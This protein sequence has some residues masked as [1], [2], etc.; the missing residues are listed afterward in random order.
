MSEKT[1]FFHI[2]YRS[3]T[4]IKLGVF[5]FLILAVSSIIGTLL[6]QGIVQ[7]ELSSSYSAGAVRLIETLGLNDFYHTIWFR[8]LL[9]LLCA[10]I[11]VCSIERL[12]K[13]LKLLRHRKQRI[14]PQKLLKFSC[15]TELS[16][17]LPWREAE[18]RLS[19]IIAEGFE[20]VKLLEYDGAY[21]GVVEKGRWNPLLVYVVHSS[22][23]LIL[24]G[25][26]IGSVFGFE[27]F[28]TLPE[29]ETSAEVTLTSGNSTFMLPFQIRCD[30]FEVSFYDTGTPKEFR[31]D[32][33]IIEKDKEIL[34]QSIRVN[35][36]LTFKGISFYQSTYGTTLK[37]SNLVLQD[38]TTGNSH[39][40]TLPYRE[41]QTIP[42][43]QDKVQIVEYRQDLARFGPAI[44]VFIQRAGQDEPKGAWVLVNRPEFHGNHA[45]NYQI[46]VT[47]MQQGQYTGLHVKQDPGI[48]VVYFGFTAML[49]GIGLVCFSSHRRLWVWAEPGE[50][51]CRVV[52]AGKT[53]KNSLAFEQEFNRI[54]DRL[55]DEWEHAST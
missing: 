3:L 28:M 15:S 7:Q 18:S 41:I 53:N 30:N 17:R 35:D 37:Q 21:S 23:L 9:L 46:K 31:S 13:T 33:T 55:R 8:L 34:K 19:K 47:D 42:D 43:T 6:P 36:P 49:V 38:L 39:E 2:L 4:S 12:P 10:N 22:I 40:I 48:W 54:C 25:A 50:K 1:G 51:S 27:G 26:L 16:I 32:V 20:P 45:E 5:V 44:A 29:G 14:T 52:I 11:T 24:I